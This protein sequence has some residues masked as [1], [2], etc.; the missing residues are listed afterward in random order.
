MSLLN[1]AHVA[2]VQG[3]AFAMS[4]HIRISTATLRPSPAAGL[5]AD[6]RILRRAEVSK[7]PLF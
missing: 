7:Q 4:P 2:A 3:A 1:E 5:H 6:R